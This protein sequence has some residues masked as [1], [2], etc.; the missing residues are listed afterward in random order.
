VGR[1]VRS[2]PADRVKTKERHMLGLSPWEL[3]IVFMAILLLFGAKRLPEIGG[4]LGKGIRGFKESIS[5]I[6]GDIGGKIAGTPETPVAEQAPRE[7]VK[8]QAPAL[9]E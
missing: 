4:S 6:E 9:P 1:I 5:G 8:A 7:P 2:L 3:L